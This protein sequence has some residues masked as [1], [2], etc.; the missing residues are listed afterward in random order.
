VEPSART[1][2]KHSPRAGS[3]FNIGSKG[4]SEK[5]FSSEEEA[6]IAEKVLKSRLLVEKIKEMVVNMHPSN[7]HTCT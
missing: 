7:C 2:L 1:S 3:T 4:T 6:Q 5:N